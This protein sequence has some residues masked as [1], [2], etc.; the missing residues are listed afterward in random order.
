MATGP[1]YNADKKRLRYADRL[2]ASFVEHVHTIVANGYALLDPVKLAKEHE[3]VITGDLAKRMTEFAED[4]GGPDWARH[5]EIHDDPPQNVA[6]RRGK[7]RPRVDLE[8]VLVSGQSGNRPRFQFEAKRLYRDTSVGDYVG[9]K[10]LGMILEGTYAHEHHNA[11][12][13]GYVQSRSAKEWA[14]EIGAKLNSDKRK[15]EIC[16][17]G[18]FRPF[19]TNAIPKDLYRSRHERKTAASPI[20]VSHVFL[21]FN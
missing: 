12:M 16:E 18:D 1:T 17:G 8:I 4:P 13:L 5:Y 9:K 21:T 19:R 15:Y 7:H 10:G 11:G 2:R 3:P 6:G 14:D 20:S